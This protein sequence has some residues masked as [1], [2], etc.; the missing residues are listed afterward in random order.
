MRQVAAHFVYHVILHVLLR[1]HAFPPP[2]PLRERLAA[3]PKRVT[4]VLQAAALAYQ[5]AFGHGTAKTGEL[6]RQKY[7]RPSARCRVRQVS[8]SNTVGR[9]CPLVA[10]PESTHSSLKPTLAVAGDPAGHTPDG[11]Q[12]QP[13]TGFKRPDA[14]VR[15]SQRK[16]LD[17]VTSKGSDLPIQRVRNACQL[18]PDQALSS[19]F[20][21]CTRD[22]LMPNSAGR[23]RPRP[24]RRTPRRRP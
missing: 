6:Q 24:A 4:P 5:I 10:E 15:G 1:R 7:L 19:Q 23:H 17:V 11:Q 14:P 3:Q 21:A 13:S 22:T 9:E 18:R 16:D 2:I 8:R 20:F 12:R